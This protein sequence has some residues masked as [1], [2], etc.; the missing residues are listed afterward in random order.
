M[1]DFDLDGMI[2]EQDRDMAQ[3]EEALRLQELEDER[4]RKV[5]LKRQIVDTQKQ[6]YLVQMGQEYIDRYGYPASISESWARQFITNP[7]L[8]TI[9]GLELALR[10]SQ[11]S[12]QQ[13]MRQEQEKMERQRREREWNDATMF[14]KGILCV[15][16]AF[17]R[18]SRK[19]EG[20]KVKR[21]RQ[22]KTRQRQR[23]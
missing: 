17:G 2:V 21:S 7:T 12:L 14:K 15:R 20:R 11:L 23:R 18:C 10:G 1:T 16:D 5:A 6:I 22:G 13:E 19:K 9:Q 4:R 8:K 3:L